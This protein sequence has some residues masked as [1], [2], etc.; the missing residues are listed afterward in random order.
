MIQIVIHVNNEGLIERIS[1][2]E[3]LKEFGGYRRV[4]VLQ[5]I[6]NKFE[7][8]LFATITRFRHDTPLMKYENTLNPI[9]D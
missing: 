7:R 8:E 4:K 1:G 5:S 9:P 6:R 2:M 3:H